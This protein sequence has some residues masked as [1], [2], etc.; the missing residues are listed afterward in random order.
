ML[1]TF[2]THDLL[3][4]RESTSSKERIVGFW[5][6][7]AVEFWH[8]ERRGAKG[9]I[10]AGRQEG[11]LAPSFCLMMMMQWEHA[12]LCGERSYLACGRDKLQTR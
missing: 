10:V 11:F 1:T 12:G 4:L 9:G 2:S 7:T 5:I 3:G 8:V 6:L